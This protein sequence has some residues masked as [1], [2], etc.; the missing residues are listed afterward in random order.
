M[1]M[2]MAESGDSY[3]SLQ[4]PEA[5]R[6]RATTAEYQQKQQEQ[7]QQGVSMPR[8]Y[9]LPSGLTKKQRKAK[10]LE[11][12]KKYGLNPDVVRCFGIEKEPYYAKLAEA[13]K[14]PVDFTTYSDLTSGKIWE[15]TNALAEYLGEGL[16]AELDFSNANASM[17]ATVCS[18]AAANFGK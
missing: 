13:L 17:L 1:M 9:N 8:A 3:T 7:E 6:V 5:R 4:P 16:A 18:L 11:L 15:R 14:R 12:A 10:V 2:R